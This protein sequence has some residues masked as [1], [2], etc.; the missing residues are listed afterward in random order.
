MLAVFFA[1]GICAAAAVHLPQHP[2]ARQR[3]AQPPLVLEFFSEM[4]IGQG[5]GHDG[6][7]CVLAAFALQSSPVVSEVWFD[8][9]GSR[10]AQTNTQLEHVDP[11][12][13]LTVIGRFDEAPPTEIDINVVDGKLECQVRAAPTHAALQ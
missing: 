9:P 12:P 6:D 4:H 5:Y 11:Y 10:L 3:H 7:G 8:A 13:N 2:D 1:K